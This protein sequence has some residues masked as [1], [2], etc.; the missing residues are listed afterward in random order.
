MDRGRCRRGF[1]TRASKHGEYEDRN[2]PS[3]LPLK[4]AN[5]LPIVGAGGVFTTV[6]ESEERG[7]E[8]GEEG[9]E[10]ESRTCMGNE[11]RFEVKTEF[12]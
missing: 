12:R 6:G 8:R 9:G 1:I 11:G 2:S 7:V 5:V 10:E 4:P 3:I